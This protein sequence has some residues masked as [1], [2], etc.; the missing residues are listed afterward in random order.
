VITT[1]LL[2]H[3]EQAGCYLGDV[4][5]EAGR[6]EVETQHDADSRVPH[7]KGRVPAQQDYH[8]AKS[9][10]YRQGYRRCQSPPLHHPATMTRGRL[11]HVSRCPRMPATPCG[12]TS[13]NARC[14]SHTR[15]CRP[16]PARRKRTS[17]RYGIRPGG[18]SA[19]ITSPSVQVGPP[20]G[21]FAVRTTTAPVYRRYRG[22]VVFPTG[23]PVVHSSGN[24][25]PGLSCYPCN[26]TSVFISLRP[27]WHFRWSPVR[28]RCFSRE[29]TGG[30]GRASSSA[31][32]TM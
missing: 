20:S 23:P 17:G 16:S 26:R 24:G 2:E 15:S 29:R 11:P 21:V 30:L 10:H 9:E 6:R 4:R 1:C 18:V 13:G 19:S 28:V 32:R 3:A 14:T 31:C 5:R 27:C 7:A 12:V 8:H 22:T 25:W